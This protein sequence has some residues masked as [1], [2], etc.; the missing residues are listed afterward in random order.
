MLISYIQLLFLLGKSAAAAAVTADAPN[1]LT[2]KLPAA[3]APVNPNTPNLSAEKIPL[4]TAVQLG[5]HTFKR[6][7]SVS[8]RF[9]RFEMCSYFT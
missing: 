7:F 2:E 4:A 9:R 6:V 5:T 8:S 1:S 3:A